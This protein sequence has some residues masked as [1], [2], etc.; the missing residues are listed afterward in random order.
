[1][2]TYL[3]RDELRAILDAAQQNRD[4]LVAFRNYAMMAVCIF[5]GVRRSELLDLRLGDV[6]SDAKMIRVRGK[7]RKW[8]A[9]P[10]AEE[11]WGALSDWLEFRPDGCSHDY[12]FTTVR[13]NRVHPSR[14]QRIWQ[15]IL[16]RSGVRREGVS[17][18]RLRHS[19]ATLLL[20]S[21]TCDIVQIQ[22][23]LGHSRID[24]TAVYLHLQPRDLQRAMARH[25]LSSGATP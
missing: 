19:A 24:T 20:Q 12:V 4:V 6:D 22:H 10:L 5:A 15:S 16:G 8:R 11:A 13:G 25:P 9:I 2:P 14:M 7:G 18:H 23:L 21:G 3:R 17:L 1:M